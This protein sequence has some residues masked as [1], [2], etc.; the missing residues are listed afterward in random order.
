MTGAWQSALA[1]MQ[2]LGRRGHHI[3]VMSVSTNSINLHSSRIRERVRIRDGQ[4]AGQLVRTMLSYVE[5]AGIDVVIPISDA[6][7]FLAAHARRN[8]RLGSRF[9]VPD[10]NAVR[11]AMSRKATVLLCRK[12]GIA[13]PRTEFVTHD[14]AAA[15]CGRLGFPCWLKISASAASQGVFR[16]QNMD[17]LRRALHKVPQSAE[18]QVQAD[19]SGTFADISGVARN[20]KVLAAFAFEASYD[21]SHGGT[22]AHTTLVKDP[23]LDAILQSIVRELNWTGGIDLDLLRTP[24]GRYLL[25][26]I[27]PRLSGTSVFALKLGIDLPA[28]YLPPG[29]DPADYSCTPEIPGATGFVSLYEEAMFLKAGGPQ[30]RERARAFRQQHVCTDSAFWDDPGYS[31]SLFSAI[32]TIQL[33]D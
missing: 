3:H 16:L 24:E 30:A 12:L 32:Q 15:T 27:N 21:M 14:S 17:D 1:C 28:A 23:A 4:D 7:A 2:S 8:S 26:E 18:L 5:Q 33:G 6:D 29:S 31:R 13:T 20:G 25:L 11:T 9:I 22:P 10:L 19:V